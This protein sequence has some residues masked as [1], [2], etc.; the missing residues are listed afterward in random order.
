VIEGYNVNTA[1]V[2][3]GGVDFLIL[4]THFHASN[5]LCAIGM[6]YGVVP[7]AYAYSGLEDTIV[8]LEQDEKNG[9]GVVF[10]HYE[11]DSLLDGIDAARAHYRKATEWKGVVKRCLANDFSWA[12]SARNQLKAYRRVTRRV[13][14][15]K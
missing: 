9:T 11:S 5:A 3:L 1:H 13:R 6:R 4:P 15:K 14:S 12:E 7:V 8:D 2:M 10:P